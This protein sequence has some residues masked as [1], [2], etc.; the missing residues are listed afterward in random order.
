[1]TTQVEVREHLI[2]ALQQDLVG[3]MREDEVLPQRPSRWYLTGFL[4]PQRAPDEQRHDPL[5]DEQV[6]RE[7][8][9]FLIGTVDK[10]AALPWRGA[11]GAIFGRVQAV[12]RE[13]FYGHAV[14]PP[15]GAERLRDGLPPPDLIIQDELHLISGP[16]GTMVGLY[17]TV[18]DTLSRDREGRRPKL[19]A[20]TATVRRAQTQIRALYARSQT[21]LFPPQGPDVGDTFFAH[22]DTAPERS[23][24]YLG[25]AAPGRSMKALAVRVYS[26][27]LGSGDRTLRVHGRAGDL[28][29]LW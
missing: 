18:V 8:P 7:L 6:Y 20:S 25:V 27:V 28:S 9:T 29:V 13:G 15:R 4:V 11:A 23:R 21:E 17:E 3:P 2:Q 16:L 22:E 12:D 5:A 19:L 1:M 10:F 26:A 24:R 14:R